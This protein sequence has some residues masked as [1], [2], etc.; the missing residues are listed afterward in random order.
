MESTPQKNLEELIHRELSKLPERPAPESLIPRVLAR[1]QAR[2]QKRWWQRSWPQWPW[3]LQLASV[4]VMALVVAAA[5]FG[6]TVLWQLALGS[7]EFGFMSTLVD[8][9]AGAWDVISVLGHAVMVLGRSVGQ[10][11]LLVALMVPVSMYLACVGL[12]TLCYRT[13]CYKR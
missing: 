3:A 2:Q 5:C 12:G 8:R 13:A 7:E 4:P 9:V 11:W 1:I 6:V 10:Q